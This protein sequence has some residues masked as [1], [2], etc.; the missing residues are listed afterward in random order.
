MLVAISRGHHTALTLWAN[1]YKV[2]IPTGGEWKDRVRLATQHV[3]NLVPKFKKEAPVA[4]PAPAKEQPKQSTKKE[5]K[6][7]ERKMLGSKDIAEMLDV[8]PATLR[9]WLRAKGYNT[10]G[11]YARYEWPEGSPR[12]DKLIK[13][14]KAS[15]EEA[16]KNN[17]EN[18]KKGRE[19]VGKVGKGNTSKNTDVDEDEEEEEEAEDLD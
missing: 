13:E 12:I 17:A 15:Q 10:E 7:P 2:P 19:A 8:K 4:K 9:R 18:L 6:E 11:E 5:T 16:K 14:F 1:K 3:N